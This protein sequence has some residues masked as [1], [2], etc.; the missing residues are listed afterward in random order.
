MFRLFKSKKL[1]LKK[2]FKDEMSTRV[3]LIQ[4]F[5]MTCFV[6]FKFNRIIGCEIASVV[7]DKIG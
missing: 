6:K 3:I 1:Q 5:C 4:I 2:I 7:N